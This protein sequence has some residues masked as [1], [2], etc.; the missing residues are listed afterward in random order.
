MTIGIAASGPNAAKSVLTALYATETLGKGAVGGFAVF[1]VMTDSGE[2]KQCVTQRGGACRLSIPSEWMRANKAAVICSG[3]D[4][5]EP[6]EQ[7]LPGM[8][9]VGLVTGHRLPNRPGFDGQP[10]NLAV[11]RR[12]EHGEQVQHAIDAVLAGNGECDAGLIAIDRDGNIGYGNT[13]RVKRRADTV[14]LERR[15]D[16]ARLVIM[17]NSI[18]FLRDTHEAPFS[19]AWECLTGSQSAYQMLSVTQSVQAL[20]AES[21][22]VEVDCTG[23]ICRVETANPNLAANAERLTAIY[24]GMPVWQSGVLKGHILSELIGQISD[25]HIIRNLEPVS[26]KVVLKK[27]MHVT[28]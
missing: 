25:G 16:D 14:C 4:R 1:A 10:L 20:A 27:E 22:R 8:N 19:L 24:M 21:D 9:S 6:L 11:L 7:F 26:G 17:H 28:S 18:Y 23:K 12:L 13:Q 2:V 15:E 5:P 3:P